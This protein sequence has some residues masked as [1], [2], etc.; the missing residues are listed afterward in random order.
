MDGTPRSR[1]ELEARKKE[2]QQKI[3]EL[4]E[5]ID[6]A[7]KRI[8]QL[9]EELKRARRE[10][11]RLLKERRALKRELERLPRRFSSYKYYIRKWALEHPYEVIQLLS[12][13]E[14]GR[15]DG[16]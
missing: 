15:G 3:F 8:K 16:L 14:R 7:R 2:L 10:Y 5:E 12:E 4:S 6:K 9:E 13:D 1:E 11:N